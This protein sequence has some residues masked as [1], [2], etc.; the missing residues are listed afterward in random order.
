ML[1]ADLGAHGAHL[2][3]VDLSQTMRAHVHVDV[4]V[5]EGPD[6]VLAAVESHLQKLRAPLGDAPACVG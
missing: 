3:V 1:V 5:A 4:D 2:A 6:A